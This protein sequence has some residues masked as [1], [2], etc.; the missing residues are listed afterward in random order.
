MKLKLK[1]YESEAVKTVER[2]LDAEVA[3][4]GFAPRFVSDLSIHK[5]LTD[6]GL[7]AVPPIARVPALMELKSDFDRVEI[8]IITFTGLICASWGSRWSCKRGSDRSGRSGMLYR[9]SFGSLFVIVERATV[10]RKRRRMFV[11]P[12]R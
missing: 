5:T 6:A 8:E 4:S 10:I 2:V 3:L 11:Y 1:I 9:R 12:A 7:T